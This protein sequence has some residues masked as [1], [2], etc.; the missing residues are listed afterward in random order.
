VEDMA[1]IDD[2]RASGASNKALVCMKAAPI[3]DRKEARP[4]FAAF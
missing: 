3:T 2:R 1:E 4:K